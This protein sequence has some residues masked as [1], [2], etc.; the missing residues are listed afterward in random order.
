MAWSYRADRIDEIYSKSGVT[1]V[2]GEKLADS[3]A[4]AEDA[5]KMLKPEKV[6]EGT[7]T[8]FQ[9]FPGQNVPRVIVGDGLTVKD[10]EIVAA[11][12]AREKAEKETAKEAHKEVAHAKK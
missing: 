1:L 4:T 5:E 2:E 3:P 6:E 9:E 12:A 8:Q 7:I 11:V 10:K